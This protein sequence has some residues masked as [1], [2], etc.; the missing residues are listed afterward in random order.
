MLPVSEAHSKDLSMDF[1]VGLPI[2]QRQKAMV[3]IDR[4][5]K[6]AHFV[7][8]H[9]ADDASHNADLYFKEIV[10]LHGVPKTIISNRDVKFMCHFW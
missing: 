3:V 10:R 8:C 6:M 7:P 9:K 2:I 4:L 5:S 1:I